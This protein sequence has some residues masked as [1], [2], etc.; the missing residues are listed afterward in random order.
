VNR[1]TDKGRQDSLRGGVE[2][3][4]CLTLVRRPVGFDYQA[5]IPRYEQAVEAPG[6][7]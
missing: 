6:I 1:D 2:I 5:A 4:L 7:T 3:M